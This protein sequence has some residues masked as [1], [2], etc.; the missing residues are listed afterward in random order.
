MS[1]SEQRIEHIP[2]EQIIPLP[3]NITAIGREED[4]MLRTD[5]TRLESRGLYR[6]DPILLRRLTPEEIAQIKAKQPWSQAKYQIV[7]GHSRWRAARELGWTQIRAIIT[8]CTPE[9]AL[10]INYKKNK[11]RGTVDPLREAAYFRHLHEVK[12]MRIDQMAEKFGISHREVE[13]ILCRVRVSP[14][15]KTL[16]AGMTALS[17]LHYEIIGSVIEPEKQ[18]ALAEVIVKEELTTREAQLAKAAI[19]KGLPPEKTVKVVKVVKREKLKPKEAR[20]VIEAMAQKPEL[21]EKIVDLPKPLL[22]EEAEKATAPPEEP[23]KKV[24]ELK[25]HYPMILIDYI[26]TRYKGKYLKDVIKAS[27]FVVFWEKLTEKE[28]EEV[29]QKAIK[30]AGEKGFEEPVIG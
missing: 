13:R 26:Y 25:E 11:A 23:F 30:M 29:A 24:M 19:E 28:R 15:A 21:A 22:V 7:D 14:E 8:D 10:E 17:P 2:L 16:L 5:M 9:E 4:M 1:Q 27:I 20:K 18:K 6:I 12:K 3:G